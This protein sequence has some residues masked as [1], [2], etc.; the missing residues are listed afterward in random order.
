MFIGQHG[1]TLQISANYIKL[2]CDSN[3][4][5]YEYE[6]IIEPVVDSKYRRQKLVSMVVR[7]DL[8]NV[9]LFDGGSV[10]YLPTKITDDRKTFI[11]TLPGGDETF[12][13][14][15]VFKK[16]KNMYDS[17]CL[18]LYNILF[19]RI[20]YIL[21]YKQMGR[22]F[23]DPT[24]KHMI[25]QHQLE[26]LPG[27]AVSVDQMEGGLFLCLDTQHKVM[28]TQNVY[29][30]LMELNA[31]DPSRFKEIAV[32][33]LIGSCV[34]TKYNNRTY[35]I[36]DINWELTPKDTFPTRD[37]GQISFLEYY[38]RQHGLKIRDINQPMLVNR[39]TVKTSTGEKEDRLICL[40]PELCHMT[41]LTESMRNDFKVS[42]R[43]IGAKLCE[44]ETFSL[45]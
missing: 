39:S 9:K 4:G 21:L 43:S 29:S 10:L 24:N 13:V 44:V 1:K 37:G 40:V 22:S 32:A 36:D 31:S 38:E 27:Y 6:V 7:N 12:E 11:T 20:M 28:R 8:D 5:V 18:H 2:F 25:P 30:Y 33:N 15:F 35:T 17:E 34:F 42:M 41:G 16:K 45:A 19:K 3:R 14:T 23:F 26:V